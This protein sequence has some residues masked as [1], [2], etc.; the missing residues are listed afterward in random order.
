[1][2]TWSHNCCRGQS[3]RFLIKWICHFRYCFLSSKYFSLLNILQ[4]LNI[5]LGSKYFSASIFFQ[6]LNI[7]IVSKYFSKLSNLVFLIGSFS[8]CFRIES[9]L[10]NVQHAYLFSYLLIHVIV[11]LHKIILLINIYYEFLR[12]KMVYPYFAQKIFIANYF[13]RKDIQDRIKWMGG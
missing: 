6:L 12:D 5:F 10:Q 7:F 2:L 3:S 9:I 13:T 1:M 4:L 8:S 11:K